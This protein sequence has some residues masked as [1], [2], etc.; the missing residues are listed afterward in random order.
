MEVFYD[1]AC[2]IC[3]REMEMVRKLDRSQSIQFTD[4]ASPEFEAAACGLDPTAIDN[5]IHAKLDDG[6]VVTGVEVFRQLYSR[7]G[8]SRAVAVTRKRWVARLLDVAYAWFARHRRAI[9]RPFRAMR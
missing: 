1:G 2:P 5:V 3:S 7:L 8:F 4:I 9:T 6:V